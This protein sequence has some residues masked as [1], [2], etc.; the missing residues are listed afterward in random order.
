MTAHPL[1]APL[2][3]DNDALN[4]LVD[5]FLDGMKS[6]GL[7]AIA[8]LTADGGQEPD[9][10]EITRY[11]QGMCRAAYRDPL[12]VEAFRTAIR[13]RINGTHNDEVQSLGTVSGYLPSRDES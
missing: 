1:L 2:L 11:V 13:D 7:S 10:D 3:D 6:G 8:S 4:V 9:V 5:V 12:M